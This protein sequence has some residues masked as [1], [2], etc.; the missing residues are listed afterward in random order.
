MSIKVGS[1]VKVKENIGTVKFIGSFQGAQGEWVGVELDTPDGKT[2]GTFNDV[3]V[4]ECKPNHGVL[5]RKIQVSWS[6]AIKYVL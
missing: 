6:T 4:F 5:V 3:V 2:D 1:R